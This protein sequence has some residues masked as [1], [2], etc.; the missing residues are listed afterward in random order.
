MLT[1]IDE[2]LPT[3]SIYSVNLNYYPEDAKG[4][5]IESVP[6]LI[7]SNNGE[8]K[9]KVYAFQSVGYLYDL[10]KQYVH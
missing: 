2:L 4:L 5:G 6:C 8:I 10:I 7:I 3:L 9:E 1:V